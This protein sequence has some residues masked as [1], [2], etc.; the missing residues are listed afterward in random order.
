MPSAFCCMISLKKEQKRNE[1]Q[2]KHLI[3][4]NNPPSRKR[5]YKQSK[6]CIY[7]IV[8]QYDVHTK[9]QY[10]HGFAYNFTM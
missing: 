7:R 2:M 6:E 4:G 3:A 5:K 9:T 1:V 8:Q 10:L